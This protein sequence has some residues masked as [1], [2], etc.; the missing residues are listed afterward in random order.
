[1]PPSIGPIAATAID[2]YIRYIFIPDKDIRETKTLAQHVTQMSVLVLTETEL[3]E[4]ARDTTLLKVPPIE[5]F[6]SMVISYI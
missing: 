3:S 4:S 5:A 1:M 2:T 6:W